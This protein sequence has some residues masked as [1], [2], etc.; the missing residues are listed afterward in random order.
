MMIENVAKNF[1]VNGKLLSFEPY[2]NG[3]INDTFLLKYDTGC[4]EDMYILQRVNKN[5]F[6]KVEE[7]MSNTT[8]V[9]RFIREKYLEKGM[10]PE[11]KCL[12]FITTTEGKC[13]HLCD[14][15]DYWRM[16][17][18]IDN[19]EA[20]DL[21]EDNAVFEKA[22]SAFGEFIA[23]LDSYPVSTL[24]EIIPNFHNTVSRFKAFDDAVKADAKD[25]KA[26]CEEEVKFVYDHK[27]LTN[28]IVDALANGEIP[29]R[30]THNDTKINNVL[31]DKTTG[32]AVCVIDLDTIMPGSLLYDFGDSIRSGCNTGLEDDKNLD[33]V[34][35]DIDKFEA[36]TRGFVGSLNEYITQKEKDLLSYAG[37]IMTFEC[38]IRFLTDY[39]QGDTYFKTA[40]PEHNLVRCRTQFKLV[41]R[42]LDRLDEM[43]A[44]VAKY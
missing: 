6:P 20:Y 16:T 37:I 33:N 22:G 27:E 3:H 11:R 2:G 44:I 42:M 13:Y 30:V 39:L 4:G 31:M 29:M 1:V 40:Y 8:G 7:L 38:G 28:I 41:S 12:N 36:F 35:F 19:T 24:Y 9:T 32:D 43:K 25:R 10:D 23:L 5:I 34:D 26:S 14:N 21:V 17:H 18:Y 15:G